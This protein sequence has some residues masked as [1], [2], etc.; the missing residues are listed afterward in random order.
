MYVVKTNRMTKS[1]KKVMGR[2][3]VGATN[4][5]SQLLSVRFTQ[6]EMN[7]LDAAVKRSKQS[8]SEWSRSTL[9]SAAL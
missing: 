4:E 5:K 9:L 7:R 3:P 6:T 8:K 2:P 1:K